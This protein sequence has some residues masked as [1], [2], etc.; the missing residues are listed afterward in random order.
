MRGET[1][2]AIRSTVIAARERIYRVSVADA[3]REEA[4]FELG[5]LWLSGKVDKR[6]LE[7][8]KEYHKLVA[9]YQR[10]IDM[11]SPY[12]Q[13]VD[14]GAARGL[15]LVAEPDESRIKRTVNQYMHSL[16]AMADAGKAASI[17][18]REVCVYDREIKDVDNLRRGLDVLADFFGIPLGLLDGLRRNG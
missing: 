16:T 10:A 12:P 2:M 18:V 14:L 3:G 9:D 15:S 7:A 17:A 13:G 6:Q 5:R 1:E 8:G 11:P 4:G